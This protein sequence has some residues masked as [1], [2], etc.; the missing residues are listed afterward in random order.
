MGDRRAIRAA[1][2]ALWPRAAGPE[3]LCCGTVN[4][5][6]AALGDRLYMTT[7]DAHLVSL[8]M[9]TGTVLFDVTLE[10]YKRGYS[11]TVAPLVVKDKGRRVS[12]VPSIRH[13]RIRADYGPIEYRRCNGS[14]NV[15]Y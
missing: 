7:L 2:L 8:D 4:R 6:F 9:K 11:A 1:D 15:G 13:K 12:K 14:T 10:D 3:F 5:G